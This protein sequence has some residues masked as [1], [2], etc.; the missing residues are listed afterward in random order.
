MNPNIM[1]GYQQAIYSVAEILL[2]YDF[3]KQVACLGFGGIPRFPGFSFPNVQ[4]CFPLSGN[5][6]K[7]EAN[8]L[9][10]IMNLYAY[11]LQNVGLNGPTLFTPVIQDAIRVS[12]L[13]K[14]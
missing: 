9:T 12:S 13:C 14:Q 6:Q 7:V 1:N 2:D 10:D 5:P 4:H 3:D 8:G 11:S